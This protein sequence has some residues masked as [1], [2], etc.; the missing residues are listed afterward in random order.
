MRSRR[1]IGIILASLLLGGCSFLE[2]A[3]DQITSTTGP[4]RTED[5]RKVDIQQ[6]DSRNLLL[7]FVHGFNSNADEAW[8]GF[9]ELIK[10]EKDTT[11]GRYTVIRY[12]YGS[13][14]CRNK[15]DIADRGEGLESFLRIELDQKKYSGLVL[16]G[17]SMGGLVIMHALE[18]MALKKDRRIDGLP[19]RVMTFGTPYFGVEGADLLRDLGFLCKDLQANEMALFN[20]SLRLLR[21]TWISFFG[22][23]PVSVKYDVML[24]VYYGAEDLFVKRDSAC[25]PFP[26][27][28]QADGNHY[29]MVKPKD[30]NLSMYQVLTAQ[31]EQLR[32]GKS[33]PQAA[34]LDLQWKVFGITKKIGGLSNTLY[35]P[36]TDIHWIDSD[37]WLSG[38]IDGGGGGGDV[39]RGILL[40]TKDGGRTWT[41][42]EKEKFNSGK[43]KFNWG[44]CGPHRPCGTYE[45]SWSE[46]G[47]ITSMLFY[48]RHLGGGMYRTEGWLS[49]YTGIY[50]TENGGEDWER[51]TPIPGDPDGYAHFSQI[52]DIEG[53]HQIYAVGWQGIAHWPNPNDGRWELQFPTFCYGIFSVT[54]TPERDIWAVGHGPNV[55]N[56]INQGAIYYLAAQSHNW[57]ILPTGIELPRNQTFYDIVLPDYSTALVVGE[58]GLILRGIRS[59]EEK[60]TWSKVESHTDEL[61]RSITYADN[62][63]WVVGT[64]GVILYSVDQGKTWTKFQTVRDKDGKGINLNRVRFLSG[65]G[66]IVGNGI[67]LTTESQTQ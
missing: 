33:T 24:Q 58:K 18:G 67:V 50:S 40:R 36:W 62:T 2:R 28:E 8:E 22:P 51:K 39:G 9:P 46:V 11:F 57:Q 44:P 32:E 10:E 45:Y 42:I 34:A 5:L 64:G 3:W 27:C 26:G 7:I 19:I 37:G 60:W 49:S 20:S 35:A 47:P 55:C 16:V 41:E 13:K 61:L 30:H 17:H 23:S 21:N 12:G 43:G 63:F 38:I 52:V 56:R 54:V 1:L 53:F 14:A 29:S 65:K 48:K 25:G 66:W 59:K 31:L 6:D 15:V 4:N